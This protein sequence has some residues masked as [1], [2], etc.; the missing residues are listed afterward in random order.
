MVK[1]Y[2]IIFGFLCFSFLCF[3]AF[4]YEGKNLEELSPNIKEKKEVNQV[5]NSLEEIKYVDLDID[6]PE[7]ELILKY[8]LEFNTNY[9][10][11]LLSSIL[12]R[13]EPYR[14]FIREKLIEYELP[15]CLEYLPVIESNYNIKAVSKSGAVG[16]WQFMEN[17]I[18]GLLTKN[19]WIDER[20][21]PWLSTEAAIK[22]LKENYEYFKDWPLALAAYNMGL[23]GLSRKIKATGCKTFWELVDGGHLKTETTNYVPKFLAIADL[24]T[25]AKYYGLDLPEYNPENSYKVETVNLSFQVSLEQLAKASS[26]SVKTLQS[27]NP[28]L[29]YSVTPYTNNF[30]LRV[31][32]AD[33]EKIAQALATLKPLDANIYTVEKGDTLWGIS[34]R[35][36]LTVD[37]LCMANNIKENQILRIGTRL[38]LPILKQ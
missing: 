29:S 1:N 24:I 15:L 38:V 17:S 16:L 6:Y 7:H 23:G 36:G 2:K 25:N 21:D 12:T 28:G 9:G 22:K 14:A 31:L 3:S 10:E 4:S 20:K 18:A 30:K 8:H 37:A 27:L 33:K 13:A 26:V 34:R 5:F 19:N 32:S 11:K 35:Y